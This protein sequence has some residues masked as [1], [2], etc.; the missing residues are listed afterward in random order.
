MI[1]EA[2]SNAPIIANIFSK[3]LTHVWLK[4]SV[5]PMVMEIL[6]SYEIGSTTIRTAGV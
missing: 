5:I 1:D 6:L 3:E 4:T 2:K